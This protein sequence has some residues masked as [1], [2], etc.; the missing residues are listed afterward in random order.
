VQG[1]DRRGETR[2]DKGVRSADGNGNGKVERIIFRAAA[3]ESGPRRSGG[4]IAV[5]YPRCKMR[6]ECLLL[7][8]NSGS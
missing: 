3:V 1:K 2:R 4:R 8:E 5:V 6:Q 7:C